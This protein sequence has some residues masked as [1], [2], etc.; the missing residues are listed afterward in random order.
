MRGLS[1]PRKKIENREEERRG[2]GEGDKE[3]EKGE[4]AQDKHFPLR[5]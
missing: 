2:G 4:V 3:A 1:T 5:S